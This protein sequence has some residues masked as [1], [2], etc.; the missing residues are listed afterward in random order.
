MRCAGAPNTRCLFSSVE[1]GS[2]SCSVV[3]FQSRSVSRDLNSFEDHS[4]SSEQQ[5]WWRITAELLSGKYVCHETDLSDRLFISSGYI[6]ILLQ[7]PN[8]KVYVPKILEA[9][10]KSSTRSALS[11]PIP[12]SFADLQITLVVFDGSGLIPCRATGNT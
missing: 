2:L 4:Q 11:K 6:Q 12:D 1:C 8:G 3:C 9:M 10:R 5:T 7:V